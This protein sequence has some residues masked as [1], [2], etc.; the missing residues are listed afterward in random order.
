MSIIWFISIGVLAGWIAGEVTRGSGY[1]LLASIIAGIFGAVLGGLLLDFLRVDIYGLFGKT[2]S[3]ILGA[4]SGV[5]LL[6]FLP[7][8][9]NEIR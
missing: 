3:A 8:T 5:Y 2:M 7:D 4:A 1:G 9:N 6:S